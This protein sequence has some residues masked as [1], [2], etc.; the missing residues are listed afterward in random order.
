M[1]KLLLVFTLTLALVLS[2]GLVACTNSNKNGKFADLTTTESVYGFS[3]ASA[4]MLISSMNG[5]AVSRLAPASETLSVP[6]DNASVDSTPK[7]ETENAETAELNRYMA[8]VESLLSDGGFNFATQPSDREG[9][10]EKMVVSYQDLEG[11]TLQY[12]MYYNQ[13]LT[14]SE[15]D[16]D[17][18]TEE[19]YSIEGVMV[20][21]GMDYAIRGE[22]S[23]ENEQ[24]ESETETKFS[25]K[26]SDTRYIL[27][28]QSVE[29]EEGE[30]ELEYSYSVY[31]NKQLMERSTFSYE[32]EAGETELK[33]TSFQDGK[34]QVFSFQK[35]MKQ[36]EEVIEI[37]VGSGASGKG[38]VVHVETDEN[39][40]RNYRYE[41]TE[42]DD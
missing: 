33:M 15:T 21:D 31:E 28:E 6:A 5:G 17:G 42:F 7:A 36:G 2:F 10:T 4:G 37:H 1:K 32:A 40:N 30:T 9:Y 35:E 39:G 41:A 13:I 27:V 3:A 18:E 26:L 25:V 29:T 16:E 23:I 22:R 14:G 11:K 12:V 19:N 34:T 8:L 20:I 38:Y 24:D